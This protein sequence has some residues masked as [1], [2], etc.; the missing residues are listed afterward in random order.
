MLLKESISLSRRSILT[1]KIIHIDMDAF[2]ASVEIRENPALASQPV[3]IGSDPNQR[4]VVATC[5]YIAR[6]F[7]VHS[8]MS[9]AEAKKCC[10]H[11]VF[12]PPNM[13]LYKQVSEDIR[14]I[15]LE[16]TDLVEPL[17]LDEAYLDVSKN[18]W[19]ELSAVSLAKRLKAEIKSRVGLTASAG[20][21]YNK[22]LAKI[23]SDLKKPDGLSI[24]LPNEALAFLEKLEIR[25]FFG[26]GKV[27]QAK[28]KRLGIHTGYDLKKHSLAFLEEEFGKMGKFYYQ[29][30]RGVDER[31]VSPHRERK[32]IAKEKTFAFDISD[33]RLL[34][35]KLAQLCKLV[36]IELKQKDLQA[37][38]LC[39]KL[40]Q[41]NFSTLTK[42]YS[43]SHSLED[44]NEVYALSCR[45]FDQIF[46]DQQT[47]RLIGV[48]LSKLIKKEPDSVKNES[49]QLY[50]AL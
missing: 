50:L 42:S 9:S 38:T 12:L 3:I 22:F 29:A 14:S 23:A 19:G 1:Q 13:S 40:R 46:D 43:L 21:S 10:P 6:T 48:S 15:F 36:L 37:R 27:T 32:S 39:L 2:Y 47:Y 5:N 24:I 7:G 44:E 8:A 34:K 49:H 25:K 30:V 26:V 33:E 11:A 45:L 18:F 4:G 31:P 41:A 20:V 17:S 35:E 28:M 16:V